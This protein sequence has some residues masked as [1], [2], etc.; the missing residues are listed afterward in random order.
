MPEM[1]IRKWCTDQLL[2]SGQLLVATV[3]TATFMGCAGQRFFDQ[4]S[5]YSGYIL[6][7][8]VKT[9]QTTTTVPAGPGLLTLFDPQGRLVSVVKDYYSS[10]EYINGMAL[11]SATRVLL[12]TDGTDRVEVLNLLNSII[13]I[14]TNNSQITGAPMRQMTTDTSGNVYIIENNG[15]TSQIEKADSSGIRVGN[16]FIATTTGSCNLNAANPFGVTY[17]PNSGNLAVTLFRNTAPTLFVY[18]ASDGSCVST[19]SS[20]PFD[21]GFPT[22]I[23][24][25]PQTNKLLVVRFSDNKIYSTDTSGGSASL[26]LTSTRIGAPTALF[27][28]SQGFVWVG[29]STNSTVEKFSFDGTTLSFM[30]SS[31][32]I[33]TSVYVQNPTS[34]VVIP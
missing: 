13:D 30:T 33:N 15:A 2:L 17:I 25:H 21:S 32:L 6:V 27:V 34:I 11:A 22:A 23:A 14:F 28:D 9:A 4:L 24:Y 31:P 8:T 19:V 5:S 10:G 26:L 7:S 29:S 12:S 3:V 20:V 16:P 18:S 1:A